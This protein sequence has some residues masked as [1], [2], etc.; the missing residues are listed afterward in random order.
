MQCGGK[1]KHS[2]TKDKY[3]YLGCSTI[4]SQNSLYAGGT[5]SLL[6][7]KLRLLTIVSYPYFRPKKDVTILSETKRNA[8]CGG[9]KILFP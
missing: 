9:V 8:D 7:I 6:R 4:S 1:I 2:I 5:C 3:Y